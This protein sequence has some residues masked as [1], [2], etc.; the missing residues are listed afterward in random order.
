VPSS[1][2]YFKWFGS[3][4]SAYRLVGYGGLTA[5]L[6]DEELLQRLRRLL[7]AKGDLTENIIDRSD[8]P[9][10][11]T[12]RNRFGSISRAYRLIGFVADPH[13]QRGRR[14]VTQGL[15]DD[16]LLEILR[17]LLRKRRHLSARI[18]NASKGLPSAP[19][20]DRRFAVSVGHGARSGHAH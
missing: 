11:C 4:R 1:T 13:T 20:Y 19:A 7:R 8:L 18:I 6:S 16:Q 14:E 9:N 3:L 5:V 15:S 17:R 10:S 2:S 12:Y